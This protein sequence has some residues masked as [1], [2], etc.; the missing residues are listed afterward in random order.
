MSRKKSR[1][2]KII[3]SCS[4]DRMQKGKRRK[5][6]GP[7]LKRIGGKKMVRQ[8]RRSLTWSQS[9]SSSNLARKGG[10]TVSTGGEI[11]G[12]KGRMRLGKRPSETFTALIE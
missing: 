3:G 7:K 1:G 5:S 11:R 10:K 12:G 6:G 2:L 4:K 9:F 8:R